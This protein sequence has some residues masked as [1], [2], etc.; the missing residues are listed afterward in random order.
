MDLAPSEAEAFWPV[1]EGYQK[2]LNQINTRLARVID[3]YATHY[4]NNTLT[5]EAA[6]KLTEETL[7][8]DESEV[9]LRRAYVSRL[10]KVLPARK[11]ARYLQLEG[12][13]HTQV[14]YELAAGI[15]LVE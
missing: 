2:E 13:I 8:V 5:D 9:K 11:V 10:S 4:R 15:P 1:Y 3:T 14:R 7:A 6:R 12:R